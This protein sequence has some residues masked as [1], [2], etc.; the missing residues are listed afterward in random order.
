MISDFTAP[1]GIDS[2]FIRA[3]DLMLGD[4]VRRVGHPMRVGVVLGTE[5][6]VVLVRWYK[7][8]P[9]DR[10]HKALL[11]RRVDQEGRP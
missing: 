5:G 11:Q 9:V 6:D 8:G 2:Y 10:R 3:D 1:S 4:V 7:D